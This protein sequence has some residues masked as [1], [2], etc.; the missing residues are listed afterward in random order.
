MGRFYTASFDNIGVSAAQDLW[1][2]ATAATTSLILHGVIVGQ[3]SDYGDAAA[4]GLRILIIRG[5]TTVGSGGSAVTPSPNPPGGAAASSTVRRNDTTAATGGSPL[6]MVADAFNIQ[7]GYQL[8]LPPE[9][10]IIVAP[11][12]RLVVNL[13]AA[14]TDVIQVSSTIFFEEV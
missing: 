4:E 1:G 13:P 5:A 2:I 10:R 3:S 6:T 12:S 14:P 11:S 8:W 9:V 7:A